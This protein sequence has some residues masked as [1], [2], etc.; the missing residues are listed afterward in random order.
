VYSVVLGSLV[1]FVAFL[2]VAFELYVVSQM[3]P[4]QVN[5]LGTYIHM[6]GFLELIWNLEKKMAVLATKK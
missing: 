1:S 3:L 4:D 5:D 2:W 6:L